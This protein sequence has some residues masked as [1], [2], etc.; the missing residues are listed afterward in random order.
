MLDD[1]HKAVD[2]LNNETLPEGTRIHPFMDRTDLVN[3]D[4][5]YRIAYV[6]RGYGIGCLSTDLI[7]GE[8]A[9]RFVGGLNHS[10][11]SIDCLYLDACY[12]YSCEPT[13][14]RRYRLRYF[15]RR[16]DRDDGDGLE[17]KG[18]ASG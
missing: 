8:L 10:L 6:V 4:L 3:Y 2:E 15:G 18:T 9:W 14:L 5:A 11:V 13:F 7:L 16:S 12:E 1:V 17:E